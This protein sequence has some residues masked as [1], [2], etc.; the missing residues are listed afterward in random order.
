MNLNLIAPAI[1]LQHKLSQLE[2]ERITKHLQQQKT[3]QHLNKVKRSVKL[4]NSKR[5]ALLGIG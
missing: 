1:L 3:L 5:K 2:A 4:E